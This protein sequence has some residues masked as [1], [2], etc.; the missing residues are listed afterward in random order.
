MTHICIQDMSVNAMLDEKVKESDPEH[1]N[2]G[3]NQNQNQNEMLECTIT[4]VPANTLTTVKT[5]E[6]T[7][8]Q[9][10]PSEITSNE[11]RGAESNVVHRQTAVPTSLTRCSAD[12]TVNMMDITAATSQSTHTHIYPSIPLT[13]AIETKTIESN[14][15]MDQDEQYQAPARSQ[16]IPTRLEC[17]THSLGDTGIITAR[18]IVSECINELERSTNTSRGAGVR[19][20]LPRSNDIYQ[21][22]LYTDSKLVHMAS[23]VDYSSNA[24]FEACKCNDHQQ[25]QHLLQTRQNHP[26]TRFNNEMSPL[27]LACMVASADVVKVLLQHGAS[28]NATVCQQHPVLVTADCSNDSNITIM[29]ELLIHRG[30]LR[31]CEISHGYNALMVAV[32]RINPEMCKLMLNCNADPNARCLEGKS[33]L[34]MAV[35]TGD[36]G[37]VQ[38]LLIRKASDQ[39][40]HTSFTALEYA[41][42]RGKTQLALMLIRS[43]ADPSR[44]EDSNRCAIELAVHNGH[45]SLAQ[46]MLEGMRHRGMLPDDVRRKVD[47]LKRRDCTP[48][49][50]QSTKVTTVPPNMW[51]LTSHMPIVYYQNPAL[52]GE[53]RSSFD[54]PQ[55]LNGRELETVHQEDWSHP[56]ATSDIINYNTVGAQRFIPTT[57]LDPR[58]EEHTQR[59]QQYQTYCNLGVPE[60]NSRLYQQGDHL[61]YRR[62]GIHRASGSIR[63]GK[64]MYRTPNGL[65]VI[66]E[67]DMNCRDTTSRCQPYRDMLPSAPHSDT[68]LVLREDDCTGSDTDR[69]HNIG[70]RSSEPSDDRTITEGGALSKRKRV[71]QGYGRQGIQKRRAMTLSVESDGLPKLSDL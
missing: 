18:P 39:G 29:R 19:S 20:G 37:I 13:M 36:V 7:P 5:S 61:E 4:Q 53:V 11:V 41:C 46:E 70:R 68:A 50:E 51:P 35:E 14:R 59:S 28:P 27:M 21:Q 3:Q 69:R 45:Y 15:Y 38:A 62:G 42:L 31:A 10:I 64:H 40:N 26:E 54:A 1:E 43:G 16:A 71:P 2:P 47:P 25:V 34:R 32:R 9:Y 44:Y 52:R 66:R 30:S 57:P 63:N 24:L 8:T 67:E 58:H 33:V 23:D 55:I 12:R 49:L 17:R 6:H 60:D 48:D 56:V 65:D 22:Y